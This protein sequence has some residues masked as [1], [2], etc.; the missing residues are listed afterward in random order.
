ML[1][2]MALIAGWLSS[3]ENR[4]Q[5]IATAAAAR[6]WI[7]DRPEFRV[8]SVAVQSRSP[9]VAAG[10]EQFLAV[11][12]PDSS[13]RL[14]YE[15]IRARAEMLDAVERASVQVR[16][17]VLQI[18]I[19]ERVPAMVWRNA[20]GLDLIDANGHRVARLASRA[21]RADLPLIAGEGAP[22]AI[23]EARL[24]WAAAAP[25]RGRIRGFV[26]VG[27]RRW[28]VVLDHGQRILLPAEG[29]LGALERA[30]ALHEG[31]GLLSREVL[32]VDLRNP[33]RPTLRLTE[34]AMEEFYRIRQ[35]ASGAPNG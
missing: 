28:N 31:Q 25:L 10:V 35:Q 13:L 33:A 14:D 9:E 4:A 12:L 16:D 3:A 34:G 27:A 22:A 20:G 5:L 19:E 26:R 32:D 15:A 8:S 6:S 24:L 7:E 21:A 1:L 2:V 17:G 18:R 29:A 11:S 30:M 23:A